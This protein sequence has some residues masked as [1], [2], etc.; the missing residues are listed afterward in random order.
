MPRHRGVER[1]FRSFAI[2]DF[3]QQY[4]I[5]VLPQNGLEHGGEIQ[6]NLLAHGNLARHVHV[7]LHR[8]LNRDVVLFRGSLMLKHRVERGRLTASGGPG[9]Q[10]DA[11]R[12][13]DHVEQT[14]SIELRQLQLLNVLDAGV[15]VQH[16][17]YDFLAVERR[18]G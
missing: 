9:G 12:A 16:P 11:L 13:R 5:R 10:D 8:V 18:Q 3:T 17:H 2:T 15:T 7:E 6:P 1:H 4:D 14:L